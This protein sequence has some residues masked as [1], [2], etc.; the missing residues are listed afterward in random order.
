MPIHPAAAAHA[1][2][3]PPAEGERYTAAQLYA[4][5]LRVPP[6]QAQLVLANLQESAAAG[7]ACFEQDH[8]GAMLMNRH[9]TRDLQERADREA[10]YRLAYDD[11]ELSLDHLPC[12]QSVATTVALDAWDGCRELSDPPA[13]VEL[14]AAIASHRCP[15]EVP[16]ATTA[17][18]SLT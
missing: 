17:P 12:G 10:T 16:C 13:M 1:D 4:R 6:E 7:W 2:T 14:S 3:E 15:E 11:T 5:L 18:S 9:L 8:H